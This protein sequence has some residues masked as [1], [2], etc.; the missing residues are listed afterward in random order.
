MKNLFFDLET[1]ADP[2]AIP[3]LPPIKAP[4]NYKDPVKIEAY[5]ADGKK[6][7][8]SKMGLNPF[9]SL[10]CVFGWRNSDGE[11]GEIKLANV[12]KE[13]DLLINA[14]EVIR[15]HDR[16]VTFN[17]NGFDVP[18]MK[19]HSMIQRVQPTMNIQTKRYYSP[20]SNHID[21]RA[22]IFSGEN[23][24]TGSLDFICQ[25]VLGI[26]K[27]SGVDGSKVQGMW[28]DGKVDEIAAYCKQD[29][30][31]THELFDEVKAAY[32]IYP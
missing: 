4:G 2:A 23:N 10:I 25:R 9:T 5:L 19:I 11:S 32:N 12:K 3:F 29:V 15:Q 27:T 1:I 14:W 13:E 6:T 17:G 18:I 24:P 28:D 26:K 30:K 22:V 20:D 31:M 21:L 7:Q 16:L 8:I